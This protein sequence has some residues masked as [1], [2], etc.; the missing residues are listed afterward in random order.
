[1]LL[2]MNRP[3][4][5]RFV[6]FKDGQFVTSHQTKESNRLGTQ[7][8]QQRLESMLTSSLSEDHTLNQEE[9][10]TFFEE[11]LPPTWRKGAILGLLVFLISMAFIIFQLSK[12]FLSETQAYLATEQVPIVSQEEQHLILNGQYL[13]NSTGTSEVVITDLTQILHLHH[14]INESYETLKTIVREYGS[15]RISIMAKNQRLTAVQTELQQLLTYNQGRL[16]ERKNSQSRMIYEA[17]AKRLEHILQVVDILLQA[18]YRSACLDQL[19]LGIE[20][21]RP[22]FNQQIEAF[23]E[24]LKNNQ[25]PYTESEGKLHFSFEGF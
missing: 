7:E 3:E 2:T 22:L 4:R 12:L 15:A 17:N 5:H 11:K 9:P 1:M 10:L 24:V 19:N 23:K 20:Q 14:S 18:P 25:I 6:E 8:D 21:D 13:T 16:E